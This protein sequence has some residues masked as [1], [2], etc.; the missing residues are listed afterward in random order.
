MNIL[1]EEKAKSFHLFNN[2][3]SYRF[4]IEEEV[5][6]AHHY[7]GK[8]IKHHLRS[9]AFPRAAWSTGPNPFEVPGRQ[10]SLSTL[11]Q[12]YPGNS[13]GD[14]RESAFSF[15]YQDGSFVTQLEYKGFNIIEGKPVIK[16]LPQTYINEKE[17]AK[18]LEII[19]NDALYNLDVIL[20]YTIFRDYSIITRSTKIRNNGKSSVQLEK[21]LSSSID[22]PHS[23]FDLIQL[24]GSWAREREIDRNKLTRGVHKI[25]SKRGTTHHSYQPFIGLTTPNTT[26]YTGEVYG[27]HFV[28]TGEF[29]GNVEVDEYGQ[30]RVQMGI[31]PDHFSWKLDKGEVFQAPEVVMVYS[32]SGLNGMSQELHRLYQNHLIRT[33]HQ[34]KERPILINNWEA[35]YFDFSEEKILELADEAAL[36]GVELFVLDDGWFG[37]RDSDNSSLG[38]W[39]VY[40][41]KLP[42]GLKHLANEVHKKGMKFGLWLEPEMISEDSELYQSHPEWVLKAENRKPSRAREQYLLD[43]SQKEVCDYILDNIQQIL[44]NVPIDYIKWDYN[45]NMTEHGSQSQFI[46]DGEV[47]HRNILGLYE[48]L[49]ALTTRYPDILWESCS[50]GGGRYDPGM[51]YYMPQT[52]TSDNT[53]AGARLEIQYG[54]SLLMPISSMGAHV[55]DIPNHQV[56]RSTSL[57]M[58]GNVA[59]AG[60]FGYELDP[61]NLSEDEK[62]VVKQQI[63]WYKSKRKLIQF[64]KFY[65][66]INPFESRNQAAWMFVDN[67]ENEA[68]VFYYQ[69]MAKANQLFPIVK[70]TG[71]DPDKKYCL[72]DTNEE[73]YGD[74]LMYKGIFIHPKLEGDF[75]SKIIEIKATE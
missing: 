27:F 73:Y 1:Y 69:A 4:A 52:W 50:G 42:N 44:D 14:Y 23:D 29:V 10:F 41:K 17:E 65:R 72:N 74:E 32:N 21:I 38:D 59:M 57:E 30:T 48:I 54:T 2:H 61:S 24:P 51:L 34:Y 49:D 56:G 20:Q 53:D 3:M 46:H 18:T 33:T 22:F 70:M 13:N 75:S 36:L 9:E 40:D 26:E 25:D 16:N 60:N 35:T 19:L 7:W 5:Y 11:L 8:L 15:R 63:S 45:R 62:E 12:E 31:N 71:L 37:H 55:S 6:L 66:L 39:F 43:F 68:I 28:Y 67:E 47:M 58:R 64:G